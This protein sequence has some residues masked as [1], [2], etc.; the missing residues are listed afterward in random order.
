MPFARTE[1]A[2]YPQST[3]YRDEVVMSVTDNNAATNHTYKI[4]V[5][6]LPF[7]LLLTRRGATE[8][9]SEL[10]EKVVILFARL[11]INFSFGRAAAALAAPLLPGL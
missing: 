6:Q 9:R 8:S 11:C 7:S 2:P 5:P 10:G 3:E 4:P 1:W